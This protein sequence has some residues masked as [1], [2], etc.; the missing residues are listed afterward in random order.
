MT[1]A[2]TKVDNDGLPVLGSMMWCTGRARIRAVTRRVQPR[3]SDAPRRIGALEL[4][5]R[6]RRVHLAGH[7][8]DLTPKGF[9]LLAVLME[10]PGIVQS[11][12]SGRGGVGVRLVRTQPH[13]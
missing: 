2:A 13:R 5:A 4:D 1:L 8:I 10:E 3:A 7:E 6:T 9:D 11:P 12:S